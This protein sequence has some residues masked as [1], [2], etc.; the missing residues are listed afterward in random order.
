MR[1]CAK[2]EREKARWRKYA[3]QVCLRSV[4]KKLSRTV[5][6]MAE[7]IQIDCLSSWWS[8]V[9]P[10]SQ[11]ADRFDW[12]APHQRGSF[13]L[14][15]TSS[16]ARYQTLR[17][18]PRN[19]HYPSRHSSTS[20]IRHNAPRSCMGLSSTSRSILPSSTY[21]RK[22]LPSWLGQETQVQASSSSL[23]FYFVKNLR[24][25]ASLY[26]LNFHF[27]RHS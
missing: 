4:T 3:R 6:L 26:S 20:R 22:R 1:K 25:K 16:S 8:A 10:K 9:I 15:T 21:F 14:I 12:V 13:C 2:T 23:I 11:M 24:P 27:N 18:T 5:R 7:A 19:P 17:R